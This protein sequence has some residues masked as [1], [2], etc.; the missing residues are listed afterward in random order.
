MAFEIKKPLHADLQGTLNFAA[1]L[2]SENTSRALIIIG[3]SKVEEELKDIVTKLL[4][5]LP[6]GGGHMA[7]V[8]L[9]MASS[10]LSEKSADCLGRIARIRN[11][12]AHS[13][14]QCSLSN[15]A[16]SE[17]VRKLFEMLE[18]I[19]GGFS[20]ISD[21]LFQ[22]IQA[23]VP[24]GFVHATP[25]TW[26]DESTQKFQTAILIFLWHFAFVKANLPILPAPIE[27]GEWTAKDD[28]AESSGPNLIG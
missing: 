10:I 6:K 2:L 15:T 23:K 12:F 24:R 16:I 26:I 7:R 14:S 22:Q 1:S 9:L 28:P 3:A 5:D 19:P 25:L 8:Q 13:S 27:I 17:D 21:S 11:H 18:S 4:P 20:K